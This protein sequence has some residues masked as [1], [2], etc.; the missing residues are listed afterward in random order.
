MT[1]PRPI[2]SAQVAAHKVHRRLESGKIAAKA[3]KHKGDEVLTLF[4]ARTGEC[5]G[6]AQARSFMGS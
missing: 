2:R 5:A 3:I 1:R 6:R 4:K